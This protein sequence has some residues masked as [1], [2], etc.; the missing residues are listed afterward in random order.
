MGTRHIRKILI[1]NRGEI[2]RRVMA[3]CAH[4]GIATVAVFSDADERAPF[5]RSADEA[6]RIGPAPSVESY[7]CIDRIV[8]AAQATGA[9]AVHPG[10]G[11]LAENAAFAQ[12]C[13]DAGLTFIGPPAAVLATMGDKR[14]A[15]AAAES[16]GV[17]VVPGYDGADQGSEVFA[18][19]AESIGYPVLLKASAG[20]GG[21]G[22]RVVQEAASLAGAM[23]S[24]AREAQAS[25]GDGTLLLEKYIERP[26]HVEVQILA[27]DHGDVIHLGERECSVQRRHQ[28]IIEEAP[29]SAVDDALRDAMGT[30]AVAVAKAAGYRNAGTVEFLLAPDG[31]FYFLE[32]NARIQVEHRVTEHV[33][34]ID[35][36]SEQIRI[37]QGQPLGRAQEEVTLFGASMEARLYAEDAT[38][39]FFPCTGTVLEYDP[40]WTVQVDSGVELG[41][42]V[43]VH[44]DPMLAKVIAEGRNREE[45]RTRLIGALRKL[46]VLGVTT[47]RAFLI[48]ALEHDAFARGELHT[49]F[50][51][52]H[53]GDALAAPP[54]DDVIREAAIAATL[55]GHE[56]RRATVPWPL[57]QSGFRSHHPQ[58]QWVVYDG[59]TGEVRV[60]YRCLGGERFEVRALGETAEIR[61][62]D[63][64]PPRVTIETASGLRRSVRVACDGARFHVQTEN[65]GFVLAEQPRFPDR[66]TA[67]DPGA[68]VAPMPG[69]I[70]AVHVAEGDQVTSGQ[71]IAIMEAMKMEHTVSAPRDGAITAL[72][73]TVGDQVQSDQ[74]LAVIAAAEA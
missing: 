68:A 16:A 25:F 19:A 45:A 65:D 33:V 51:D 54:A 17:F 63:Y 5:V 29:S 26:R 36:V 71:P 21:K 67:R 2:A 23:E 12:A 64:E 14:K 8:E 56:L 40:P 24:A 6:V 72:H 74:V 10:Y 28:K 3:T 57:V 1:A 49:G 66:R 38:R 30:A 22:M 58:D 60:D 7:L 73:I 13:T 31:Q 27:D 39:D 62:I 18:A 53:F 46:C 37:A 59:P 70:T 47:N 11:F 4:E 15:R 42:E 32:V 9:D 55:A 69:V 35:L 50:I 44:Y 43:G 61:L 48:R 34:G 52:V 41:S 20:G